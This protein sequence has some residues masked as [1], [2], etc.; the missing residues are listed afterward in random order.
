MLERKQDESPA[1]GV[2]AVSSYIQEASTLSLASL[3]ECLSEL[4]HGNMQ[5]LSHEGNSDRNNFGAEIS[6]GKKRKGYEILR[7]GNRVDEIGRIDTSPQLHKGG[8]SD[9]RLVLERTGGMRSEKE[10]LGDQTRETWTDVWLL[11]YVKG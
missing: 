1:K 9:Q 3:K 2:I 4:R 8:K 6:S 10:K 11:F 5:D 7:D